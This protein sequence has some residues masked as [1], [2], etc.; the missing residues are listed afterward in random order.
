[1]ALAARRKLDLAA[2]GAVVISTEILVHPAGAGAVATE[3]E[4]DLS[5]QEIAGLALVAAAVVAAVDLMG[6]EAMETEMVMDG[7]IVLGVATVVTA[8][9]VVAGVMANDG[10]I[11]ARIARLKS[12]LRQQETQQG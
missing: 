8:A 6:V 9:A 12:S 1:M 7:A 2:H 3:A 11:T 5:R 4:E 10:I